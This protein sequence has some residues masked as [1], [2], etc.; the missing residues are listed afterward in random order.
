MSKMLRVG[1]HIF[2]DAA[3]ENHVHILAKM[4][5]NIWY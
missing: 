3:N 4:E 5:Y 1:N 2:D